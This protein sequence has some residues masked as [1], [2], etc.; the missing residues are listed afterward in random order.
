MDERVRE[1]FAKISDLQR[2]LDIIEARSDELEN[3][4]NDRALAEGRRLH[5]RQRMIELADA[6]RILRDEIE[7]LKNP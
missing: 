7:K 4:T 1:K 2:Q 6:A 5:L 3:L